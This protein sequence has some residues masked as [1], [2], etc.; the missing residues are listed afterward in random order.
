MRLVGPL[1]E[2][3]GQPFAKVG[4]PTKVMGL[5]ANV[6][7]AKRLR[8]VDYDLYGAAELRADGGVV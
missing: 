6:V 7:E 4:E 8:G 3:A 1:S 5:D 2:G